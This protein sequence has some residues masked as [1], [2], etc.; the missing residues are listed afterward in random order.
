MQSDG[1]KIIVVDSG[2]S[3]IKVVDSEGSPRMLRNAYISSSSTQTSIPIDKDTRKVT[4]Q[5]QEEG[6]GLMEETRIYGLGVSHLNHVSSTNSLKASEARFNFASILSVKEN[7]QKLK[8]VYIHNEESDFKRLR[9]DLLGHY[10]VVINDI[11]IMCEVVEVTFE[12]EG[13]G[14]YHYLVNSGHKFSS[15]DLRILDLGLG[16]ANDLIIS[17]HGK[18]RFYKTTNNLSVIN[19][20]KE[21]TTQRCI[22]PIWATS[23]RIW[24]P[25]RMPLSII[26]PQDLSQ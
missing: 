9:Q 13:V 16:L 25:S 7:N 23:A 19:V 26:R 22:N 5:L 18:V 17:S 3:R 12:K 8:V 4:L 1:V 2:Y 11:P 20:A 15:G 10:K 6:L 24:G 14:T 21:Y